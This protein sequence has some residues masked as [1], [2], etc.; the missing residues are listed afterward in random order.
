M[1][2]RLVCAVLSACAG[3]A[4][5]QA[6]VRDGSDV[7]FQTFDAG[8]SGHFTLDST[9]RIILSTANQDLVDLLNAPRGWAHRF[10]Q[11]T[12]LNLLITTGVAP[13]AKDIVLSDTPDSTFD[14]MTVTTSIVI[15]GGITALTMTESQVH[16]SRTSSEDVKHRPFSNNTTERSDNIGHRVAAEGYQYLAGSS[17]LTLKFKEDM[18]ALRGVQSLVNLVMQDGEAAGAHRELP[19]GSGI[20]YPKWEYR[21]LM[22]DVGRF[23]MPKEYIFAVIEKMAQHKMNKLHMHLNDDGYICRAKQPTNSN[24]RDGFLRLDLLDPADGYTTRN[25]DMLCEGT[26]QDTGIYYAD[27]YTEE[28]WFQILEAAAKHGVEVVPELD[29]PSHAGAWAK[30]F[31]NTSAVFHNLLNTTI[32]RA[33]NTST[34]ANL[35]HSVNYM[36]KITK[37]YKQAGWFPGN[38]LHIGADES[39]FNTPNTYPNDVKYVNQM[40]DELRCGA[41]N[42][43]GT[44]NTTDCFERILYW[45]FNKDDHPLTSIDDNILVMFWLHD[46]HNLT[47]MDRAA[48]P[49]W[50]DA[51]SEWG[52]YMTPGVSHLQATGVQPALAYHN[53]YNHRLSWY[54][55]YDAIPQG[56]SASFW[57]DFS[58]YPE[59]HRR[60][61]GSPVGRYSR[62]Q[63]DGGNDGRDWVSSLL[64]P[65]IPAMG[66][67]NWYGWVRDSGG[68]VRTYADIKY[69]N[70]IPVSQEMM[71][72]WVNDRYP[73][74]SLAYAR[75]LFADTARHS[76]FD[77]P[78]N[79]RTGISE[80]NQRGISL[81]AARDA[82]E[83]GSDW[84]LWQH[85]DLEKAFSG[86]TIALTVDLPGEGGTFAAGGTC[87]DV[88]FA[89]GV[90]AVS[91]CDYDTWSNA[92][93][94]TGSLQ[95]KGVG[96][97]KLTGG[98]SF[99]GDLVI[100]GGLIEATAENNLGAGNVM[101]SGG[102]LSFGSGA[103]AEISA[104]K[105]AVIAAG[106]I[107]GLNV[108][109][110]SDAVAFQGV[111]SGAGTLRKAGAGK[112][113]LAN[114]ANTFAGGLIVAEGE[115][116]FASPGSLGAAAGGLTFAGGTLTFDSDIDLPASRAI[117]LA[118]EGGAVKTTSAGHAIQIAGVISGAGD[119]RKAGAGRLELTGVNTYTG[120][121]RVMGGALAVDITKLPDVSAIYVDGNNTTLQLS[122]LA[123]GEHNGNISS[124]GN[125]FKAGSGELTLNGTSAVASWAIQAGSL[126]SKG[127][128][129]GNIGFDGRGEDRMFTFGQSGDATYSGVF[130]DTG[131]SNGTGDIVKSG[132]GAL[133][134]TGDSGSFVGSF[135]IEADSTVYVNDKLGGDVDVRAMGVLGGSGEIGSNVKVAAGGKLLSGGRLMIG[136]DLNLA[137]TYEFRAG[138]PVQVKGR[139]DIGSG[140]VLLRN[141]LLNPYG[142]TDEGRF[143]VLISEGALTG[144]F[145]VT[146]NMLPFITL[147]VDYLR[148]GTGGTVQMRGAPNVQQ[149]IDLLGAEVI[150]DDPDPEPETDTETDTG[151]IVLTPR[152]L[153]QQLEDR[154]EVLTSDPLVNNNMEAVGLAVIPDLDRLASVRMAGEDVAELG[155]PP[156]IEAIDERIM[157]AV[158]AAVADLPGGAAQ[159]AAKKAARAAI[160]EEVFEELPGEEHASGS[161]A[162]VNSSFGLRGALIVP[163]RSAGG[164][165]ISGGFKS[166]QQASFDLSDRQWGMDVDRQSPA[167]VWVK[168]LSSWGDNSGGDQF[169]AVEYKDID[170]FI[171][172]EARISESLRAGIFAG[173]G[174]FEFSEGGEYSAEK[175]H[176]GAYAN[177]RQ[178]RWSLNGGFIGSRHEIKVS[179]MAVGIDMNPE[180]KAQT[181]GVFGELG[182]RVEH[183]GFAFEP[184][185]GASYIQHNT[186]AIFE[187]EGVEHKETKAKTG[188][189]DIGMHLEADM[190]A[191]GRMYTTF[192]FN[193]LFKKPD[194]ATPQQI[195]NS[196]AVSVRGT[197]MA[198]KGF[199]ADIGL[200][201]DL[202]DNVNA[203]IEYS[204][205]RQVAIGSNKRHSI[206]A[207]VTYSF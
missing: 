30:D 181:Y 184:F 192:V 186:D 98:N 89:E 10:R 83:R 151:P 190:G 169:E 67:I 115:L 150:E 34:A 146:M 119:L 7:L 145:N 197:P 174:K 18:G 117:V 152:E 137:G 13:T 122:A 148:S 179:R 32:F 90:S 173:F 143:N 31:E 194:I 64:S 1:S 142:N 113:L 134:L 112:L 109:D 37:E 196:R 175:K 131:N 124:T 114:A 106:K 206:S 156:I 163:A 47:G 203:L 96:T 61:T 12:G 94:G 6:Q 198:T 82:T 104:G 17:G 29:A 171:G 25:R 154:V 159:D 71:S 116:G 107:G 19:G 40:D 133:T 167:A 73:Y 24:S 158:V 49:L 77:I 84:M 199:T 188:V 81:R 172:G 157:E 39:S 126:F 155:L 202:S 56:L 44:I 191:A 138:S 68:A 177:W 102:T 121:T 135:A 182:Y 65:A 170:N 2:K 60:Y 54:T 8:S 153:E 207:K 110:G 165:G 123:D 74:F 58:E 59:A 178:G 168:V 103:A 118:A 120:A 88:A 28:D 180:Y 87:T 45:H 20:D 147:T 70:L 162:L 35:S 16:Y 79:L 204:F 48:L 105:G 9:S 108:T 97:L 3:V 50:V 27:Y 93:A 95:K 129:S 80:V 23:F 21:G 51:Y 195:G 136:G 41:T 149:L 100:E 26:N 72:Y 57:G 78:S 15:T 144:E 69:D 4:G 92:I 5:A 166:V 128:F 132:G 75:Q 187:A 164:G 55:R 86:P 111:V 185:A 200:D 91:V 176:A 66:L 193:L 43:Q 161:T 125:V 14:A 33:F 22:L 183:E 139:A 53:Y 205:S 63:E 141:R 127:D 160:L 201:T 101:L 46:G 189:S 140:T 85:D 76:V 62:I 11:A 52:F 130:S 42:G 99:T 38:L 36:A